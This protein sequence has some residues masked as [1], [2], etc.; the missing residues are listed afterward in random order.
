[1]YNYAYRCALQWLMCVQTYQHAGEL[2]RTL[3]EALAFADRNFALHMQQYTEEA[4][5]VYLWAFSVLHT[6]MVLYIG[7]IILM[8]EI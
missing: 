8:L 5:H 2:P 4:N 3:T 6:N 1:M 7:I